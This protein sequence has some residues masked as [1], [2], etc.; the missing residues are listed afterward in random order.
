MQYA[1]W[2][3]PDGVR[4]G[5]PRRRI[6][7]N[8]DAAMVRTASNTVV[9]RVSRIVRKRMV[10]IYGEYEQ[11]KTAMLCAGEIGERE[12]SLW[13]VLSQRHA[14]RTR[15]QEI[16]PQHAQGHVS[17][18]VEGHSRTQRVRK[19]VLEKTTREATTETL[20]SICLFLHSIVRMFCRSG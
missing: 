10:R 17:N 20:S 18:A 12:I 14:G 8:W 3:G 15:Y 4:R 11:G 5:G 13:A 19:S 16:T 1:E 9:F 6:H 7:V 2:P